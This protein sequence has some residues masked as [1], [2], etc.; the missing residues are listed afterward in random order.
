MTFRLNAFANVGLDE[1][2]LRL[3]LDEHAAAALPRLDKL[4]TY[5]RNPL[6]AVGAGP[7]PWL[8]NAD[9]STRG[10]YRQAQ[11]IGLPAR[12]VGRAGLAMD[13]RAQA[14]RE[15]VIENDIA[16]RVQAMVDFMFGK[17]VTLLST[18]RDE[19]LRRTI[20]K[21]LDTVW[22]RSGGIGLLQDMALLGHVYGHVDLLLRI[23][24]A[25]AVEKMSITLPDA[26]SSTLDEAA[27]TRA[28]EAFTLEVIEPTRGV[29]IADPADY[30]RLVAYVLRFDRQQNSI[31]PSRDSKPS[32]FWHRAFTTGRSSHGPRLRTSVTEI[33]S[34]SHHQLYHDENLIE[35]S[36]N[37]LT[38]GELPVVHIQNI[39]QPFRY[40]GQGEVE[41]LIPLQ[42]ELN[43]RLSDRASR[44]TM[45][46]FKM[47]LAKGIEGADKMSVGPGQIW[48]ADN[49]DAS[50]QEFGGDGHSPSEES[51]IQEIREALDK[52]SSVPP[53]AGG[54]VRAKI[55]N[56]SSANALKITL[57]G[58]L[59]KTARKRVTY[60]RGIA[61]ISWLVLTALDAA[62]VL[63][64]S[65]LD[66]GVRLEWPD[67]L[68]TDT[69]EQVVAAEAKARLGVPHERVLAEL[70]YSPNDPGV[71]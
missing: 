33:F 27:I 64:T 12:I 6:K 40:E 69:R 16:W 68:P 8:G 41:P 67:P 58:I 1:S 4:W 49:M 61:Q 47:Y 53:L 7:L 35:Q 30:R 43:T 18:A 13:D 60:G 52:V 55:G 24:P 37:T 19:N 63:E 50:I 65:E 62:G 17:P 71:Q 36:V 5:Y 39:S 66:R 2:L 32:T 44:V 34:G 9:S 14:R 42:D 45:Q 25:L 3:V 31:D 70:G 57:M 22:E 48:T 23:D 46:S 28:A 29:P 54:V 21:I 15:V 56:L 38:A 20:E 11:E 59:S 10:W 26:G 51:H